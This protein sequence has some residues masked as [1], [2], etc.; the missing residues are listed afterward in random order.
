MVKGVEALSLDH[1]LSKVSDYNI[2]RYYL[3][4]DFDIGSKKLMTSPFRRDSSPSFGILVSDVSGLLYHRDFGDDTKRGNCVQFVMQ[5]YNCS[6]NQALKKIDYDFNLGISFEKTSNISVQDIVK[7]YKQPDD[8]E[9]L[10]RTLIQIVPRKFT[11]K[12]LAYWNQYHITEQELKDND[13][14]SINRL[15]INKQVISNYNDNLRFAYLYEENLKIYQPESIYYKWITNVPIDHISG[16][17]K[18][19]KKVDSKTQDTKLIIEKSKKD[20]IIAKK[21]F[22][23]V[24]ST[25]NES[26]VG[27]NNDNILY[28]K[29]NWEEVILN[30]DSDEPGV[31]ACK[32][33]NQFGFK[34]FNTPKD[35]LKEGIKD[36]SDFIR[37]KGIKELENLLKNKNLI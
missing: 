9:A 37:I 17:K 24:C 6:Y 29:S 13:I 28:F 5:L 21:F 19:K 36:I 1:I 33:Y 22:K 10:K 23:D 8:Y 11:F 15:Y 4:K 26:S 27:I 31:N 32:Y 12:E 30:Y 25:Q 14:Y 16:L 18:L 20:E 7:N 34:Y 2:Y 35:L 3:E